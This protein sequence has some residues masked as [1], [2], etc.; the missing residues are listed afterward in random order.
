MPILGKPKEKAEKKKDTEQV[1]SRPYKPRAPFPGR[2]LK[3]REDD[4]VNELYR[5][6]KKVKINIPLVTAMRSMPRCTK[7]LKELC[8]M[9]FKY[10]DDAK[11]QVGEHV[12]AVLCKELPTKCGDPGMFYIPYVIGTMKIEKAM[13]DLGASI[14]VIPLTMYQDLN[15]GPL[16]LT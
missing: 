14:N 1:A 16:K 15:M 10:T 2:L 7:F 5:M 8:T 3:N 9:K 6:F 4:E 13:L 12:S 11:F